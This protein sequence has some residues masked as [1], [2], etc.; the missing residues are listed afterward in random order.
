MAL[1]TTDETSTTKDLPVSNEIWPL[2]EFNF[3][4]TNGQQTSQD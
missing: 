4:S 3:A 1:S 2:M